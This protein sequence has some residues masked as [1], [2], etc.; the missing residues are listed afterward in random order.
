MPA[1]VFDFAAIAKRLRK[2]DF[3]VPTPK[4]EE[5]TTFIYTVAGYCPACDSVEENP[6]SGHYCQICK[7]Y[8]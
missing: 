7:R 6:E 5:D 3:F 4:P 2:D 1:A 8:T